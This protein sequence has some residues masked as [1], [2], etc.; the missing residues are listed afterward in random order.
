M[1]RLT[2]SC[3]QPFDNSIQ[4]ADKHCDWS[5]LLAGL[6]CEACDSSFASELVILSQ[7][8]MS[9]AFDDAFFSE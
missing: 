3:I 4:P 2:R 7:A 9:P 5:I 8:G 6:Q 1:E